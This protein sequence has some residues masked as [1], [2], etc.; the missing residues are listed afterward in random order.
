MDHSNPI[1]KLAKIGLNIAQNVQVAIARIFGL[2]DFP[3]PA[4]SSMRKT[5]SKKVRHYY[6]SGI[7]SAVP[8]ITSA[9][10]EGVRFDKGTR[11]LDFGCGVGRQLLHFTRNLP[12]PDYYG[13]DIDDT[14]IDFVQKA[15]PQVDAHTSSFSP[16]LKYDDAF[17]DMIYS[18]SIF[19]HLNME[20]L[21]TW[22][23]ELG[24]I[25]R[26]GGYCF[27]TT[28]GET[29]ISPLAPIFGTN[30]STDIN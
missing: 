17:F 1:K 18:V 26:P 23:A 15:Y 21:G 2:V 14:S 12:E 28:E 19:S 24:R 13:C 30:E 16:P 7:Q 5:S 3:V 6:V 9:Q 27:L 22:L 20:D 11:V 25:T 4:N 10:R 29:D 8:I